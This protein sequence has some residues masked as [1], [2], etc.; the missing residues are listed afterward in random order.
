MKCSQPSGKMV[1][2]K[3]TPEMSLTCEFNITFL[4]TESKFYWFTLHLL[5]LQNFLE[6][7]FHVMNIIVSP[8]FVFRS[9]AEQ[10]DLIE[11][12]KRC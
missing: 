7:T 5:P 1:F 9:Y 10:T 11:S 8:R 12:S 4:M 3:K 2:K 6:L